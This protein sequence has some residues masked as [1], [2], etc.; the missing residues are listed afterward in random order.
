MKL[1]AWGKLD[2]KNNYLPLAVHMLDVAVCLESLLKIPNFKNRFE[3]AAERP[4]DEV[5]IS[6]LC[7]LAYLHDLGKL[8]SGF[9]SR[10]WQDTQGIS[11]AGHVSEAFEV[12]HHPEL[13]SALH[14]DE[15]AQKWGN[16]FNALFFAVMAHHGRPAFCDYDSEGI[17]RWQSLRHYDL[18]NEAKAIG[19]LLKKAFPKAFSEGLGLPETTKF[20]HLFAGIVALADQIGSR[21]DYFPI[22]R[23]IHSKIITETRQRA[24]RIV[25]DLSLDV[26]QLRKSITLSKPY[27][28]FGWP[29]GANP[30]QMQSACEDL[31][32]DVQLAILE[33]ETGSGKTEAALLRFQKLFKAGLVDGLYFAVPT[34][35]AATGLHNRINKAALEMFGA[36][37]LLAVPGYLRIGDA[38]GRA[39][40]DWKVSWDD[41]PK[42]QLKAMRWAAET[43]RR[44]LAAP[45]AVGTV[46]QVLLSGLQVKWAHFRAAALARSFLVIDEVH[47]SDTYMTK[48]MSKVL[49][50]HINNGGHALLMSATLGSDARK[51][52]LNIN[53]QSDDEKTTAYPALSYAVRNGEKSIPLNGNGRTKNVQMRFDPIMSEPQKIAQV[54]ASAVKR[55]AKVLVIRNTVKAALEVQSALEAMLKPALILQTRG[56]LF[57]HHSRYAL[58]DRKCID[59]AIEGSFGKGSDQ[60]ALVAV[61]T[62]TLEQSLDICA[63]FLIT[64]ICPIDVLLQRIGRLHRHESRQKPSEFK[65]PMCYVLGPENLKPSTKFLGFGIGASNSGKGVYPNM[66][67]LEVVRR[68][69]KDRSQWSIPEDNR[70]LVEAGTDP[71]QLRDLEDQL[72]T[73][74]K[75]AA[76]KIDGRSI[77][78]ELQATFNVLDKSKSFDDED[79]LFPDDRKISTRLGDDGLMVKLPKGTIGPFDNRIS[80]IIIPANLLGDNRFYDCV[81][82]IQEKNKLI[83]QIGTMTYS[84][85]RNGLTKC[86]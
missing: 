85:T 20:Q 48:V 47:A 67:G 25:K 13:I 73:E 30:N 19:G 60:G 5:T 39:L 34:R 9:Q 61:G 43:P 29:I 18:I 28:L 76:L 86:V 46:D 15:M 40:P 10:G 70:F 57:A 35:S 54:A 83:L 71:D 27:E 50:S 56:I 33:S 45:V 72:G 1:Q 8:N 36:E 2:Y 42:D 7:A 44:F 52:W 66:T 37:A 6:R 16:G 69:I 82:V 68:L 58:E 62:Q 55:G 26:S 81:D 51:K 64:D 23:G 63:D 80:Q 11:K 12:F 49:S 65:E 79:I 77:G 59:Q 78:D 38:Q 4:L 74:W 3:H 84:Y 22:G 75:E 14:L 53:R 31:P 21:E 17:N 24:D 32:L 41:N